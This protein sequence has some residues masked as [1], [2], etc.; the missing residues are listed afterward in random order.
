MDNTPLAGAAGA[1]AVPAT[2]FRL[3]PKCK[4]YLPMIKMMMPPHVIKQKMKMGGLKPDE[5]EARL[6]LCDPCDSCVPV[7]TSNHDAGTTHPSRDS[8]P[9][10]SRSFSIPKSQSCPT[11]NHDAGFHERR[12][13][14]WGFR[15]RR[16]PRT[17][18][19]VESEVQEVLADA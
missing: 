2:S 1:A 13:D 14:G 15:R 18:L 19:S 3:D 6:P 11:T 16:R 10:P 5:I 17:E 7:A 8:G 4:K 12:A 9:L